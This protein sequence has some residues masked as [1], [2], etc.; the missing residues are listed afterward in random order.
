MTQARQQK[1]LEQ[2][3]DEIAD[4]SDLDCELKG[5]PGRVCLRV[6]YT[7]KFSSYEADQYLENLIKNDGFMIEYMEGFSV[8]RSEPKQ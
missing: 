1:T 3:E 7:T 8:F 4:I 2:V 6:I 5:H